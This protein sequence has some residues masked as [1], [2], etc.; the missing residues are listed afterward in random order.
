MALQNYHRRPRSVFYK[1]SLDNQTSKT[2]EG[3]TGVGLFN[4]FGIQTYLGY[5]YSINSKTSIGVN[6]GISLIK[7][8]NS[9][10]FKGDARNNPIAFNFYLKRNI[11]WIK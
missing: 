11:S 3:Y 8:T 9:S 7:P 5:S 1:E 10:R 4:R 2:S 6:A